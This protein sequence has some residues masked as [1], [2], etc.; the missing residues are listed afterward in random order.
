MR[1]ADGV[2]TRRGLVVY[3]LAWCAC[4]VAID[5]YAS[6]LGRGEIA[7]HGWFKGLAPL[8]FFSAALLALRRSPAIA[9]KMLM[10][11]WGATVF[12]FIVPVLKRAF[13]MPLLKDQGPV[14]PWAVPLMAV[15]GVGGMLLTYAVLPPDSAAPKTGGDRVPSSP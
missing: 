8:V 7:A 14:L 13:T 10:S 9:R 3:T 5:A 1:I 4:F 12:L 2:M 11:G 6:T 15:L